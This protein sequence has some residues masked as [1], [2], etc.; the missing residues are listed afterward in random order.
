MTLQRWWVRCDVLVYFA[1][2]GR[3]IPTVAAE[4]VIGGQCDR[5]GATKSVSIQVCQG[6]LD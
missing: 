1:A 3:V 5:T 2:V 6:I 4:I